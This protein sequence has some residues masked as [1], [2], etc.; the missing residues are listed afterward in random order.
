LLACCC[1]P[2]PGDFHRHATGTHALWFRRRE[3]AVHKVDH[4][5]DPESRARS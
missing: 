1:D 5:L 2:E 4:L 3:P